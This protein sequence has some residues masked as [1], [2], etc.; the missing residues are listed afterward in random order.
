[1][2]IEVDAGSAIE[3]SAVCSHLLG[4]VPRRILPLTLP[5]TEPIQVHPGR[6]P[7]GRQGRLALE[8]E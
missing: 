2:T 1:M 8:D 6:A 3:A 4:V 7:R 5:D